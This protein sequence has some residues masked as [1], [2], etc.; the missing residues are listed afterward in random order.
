MPSH[1]GE[2]RSHADGLFEKR[3]EPEAGT[4]RQL[5]TRTR[6]SA[7]GKAAAESCRTANA[8]LADIG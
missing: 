2:S 5:T 3:K 4:L 1:P 6:T 8:P 7:G